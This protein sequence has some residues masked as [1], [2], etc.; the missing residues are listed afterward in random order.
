VVV[1]AGGMTTE[2]KVCTG[3][4]I[5]SVEVM[6]TAMLVSASIEVAMGAGVSVTVSC[7]VVRVVECPTKVSVLKLID[8]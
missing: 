7:T 4:G 2:E 5:A 8:A 1:E 3:A 6:G